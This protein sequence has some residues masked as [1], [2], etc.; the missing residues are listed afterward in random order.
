MGWIK[1]SV[2]VLL[3]FVASMR[4]EVPFPEEWFTRPPTPERIQAVQAAVL[5]DG[6]NSVALRLYA[7]SLKAY[8]LRQEDAAVAWHYVARWSDLLGQSQAK[9]ARAW[10]ETQSK[11]G[12]LYP[13]INAQRIQQSPDEPVS[14]LLT[15]DTVTWLLG[16]RAFSEAFFTQ[17]SPYDFRSGALAILQQLR[18]SDVR[19]FGT[20]SQLALAIALVYDTPPPATWPHAQV[21]PTVLPR[22]LPRPLD[23]FTFL[24][25]ADQ[26]GVTAQKLAGVQ[27]GELKF[28][29]DLSAGFSDLIWAQQTIKFPLEN[30]V[31]CYEAVRYRTDRV[32][33]EQFMWPGTSYGL[34]EIYK[35]GGICVDQAYFASQVGKARG[36]P[37]LLFS[38]AGQGGRHAWFGYLGAG[39]KWVLD[40][41][42]YAEQRYIVGVAYDPQTWTLLS[43]HELAFLSEGFR[44]LTPYRQS[45]QQ[46][47]FAEVYLKIGKKPQAAAAA[48]KAISFERRNFEAWQ[49]LIAASD[50]LEPKAKESLLREAALAMQRYPDLAAV[51][52]RQ[53]VASLRGRGEV[54]T[55]DME[56]RALV[57]RG[58]VK[59]RDD[60]AVT[61]AASVM[62]TAMESGDF[63]E[64]MKIYRQVLKQYAMGGGVDFYDRVTAPFLE[65]L[66]KLG[67]RLEAIQMLGQ[68]RLALK[69][70]SDSQLD[71]EMKKLE[72]S[73]K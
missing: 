17:I 52:T 48:R 59:G 35:E 70:E 5:A 33:A 15:P 50:E 24:T 42:R 12:L 10:L 63:M 23:A 29:V 67:K 32:D 40:A 26:R 49:F 14:R 68:T 71:R 39:Q 36:V 11:A 6:W 22:R 4:A 65:N 45:R 72:A 1:I 58:A 19:R 25:T 34:A 54:S 57:K 55:A 38:G 44:K 73:L 30:F 64:Q 60:F 16:D 53:L 66:L 56:E 27:A 62:A 43:D 47:L 28:A 8:E 2:V 7:G 9:V 18:E 13:E 20:Y 37:T 21:L 51:F 3:G 46:Q 69:P 41:G 31:K 61:Q